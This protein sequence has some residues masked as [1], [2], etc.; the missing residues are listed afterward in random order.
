MAEEL[1]REP[2]VPRENTYMEIERPLVASLVNSPRAVQIKV[3]IMT[4]D[5][6]RVISNMK[7]HESDIRSEMLEVMREVDERAISAPGFREDLAEMLKVATNSVLEKYEDFGGV[8]AVMFT[9]FDVQ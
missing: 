9:E 2:T 3:A 1:A 5:G 4:Q 8:E 6:D 7:K